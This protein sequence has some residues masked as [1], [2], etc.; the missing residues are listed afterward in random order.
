VGAK[1]LGM[2]VVEHLREVVGKN[3]SSFLQAAAM[4]A[5]QDNLP[6]EVGGLK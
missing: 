3:C 1:N 2:A 4:K 6:M 5:Y